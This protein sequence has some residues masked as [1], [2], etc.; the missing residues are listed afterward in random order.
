MADRRVDRVERPR[1]EGVYVSR[2]GEDK[3]EKQKFSQ[4]PED[5]D[6]KVVMATFF[7]YLKKMFDAFSPSNKIAGKV[8][9]LHSIIEHLKELKKILGKLAVQ[10]LS[11]S[12]DYAIE[13][14]E[15]W[16]I[17]LEDFDTIE[18]LERKETEKAA[19]FRRMIDAVKNFPPDSEHRFGYYLL[20]QAGKDWLPFPFI[21]ILEKLHKDHLD[22]PKAS[23]L[24]TWL[25]LIDQV[26]ESLKQGVPFN[27]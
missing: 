16:G 4:I 12:S 25:S 19:T 5:R 27:P 23:T 17:I 1:D 21:E 7:S 14:S 22:D 6:K 20:Q 3:K 9:D 13:L 24:A 2:V 26:I 10:D 18:I 8:V 15:K 11:S